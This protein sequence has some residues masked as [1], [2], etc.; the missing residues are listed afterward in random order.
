MSDNLPQTVNPQILDAVKQTNKIVDDAQ[1]VGNGIVYQQVAQ[2][3]G[4][5]VQ[6]TTTHLNQMLVLNAAVTAKVVQ[7]LLASDGTTPPPNVVTTV[8]K[9]AE[10]AVTDSVKFMTSVGNAAKEI[11]KDFST[12]V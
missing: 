8:Q 11:L 9:A 10:E 1:K 7:L 5:A 3:L 12:T 2:S 6:D 4:L